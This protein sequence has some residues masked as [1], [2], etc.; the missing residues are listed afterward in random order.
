LY[1]KFEFASVYKGIFV[2]LKIN[3]I[4]VDFVFEC[5]GIEFE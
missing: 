3:F 4:G 5:R 2:I 1:A